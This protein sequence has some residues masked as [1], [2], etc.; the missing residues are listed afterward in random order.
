MFPLTRCDEGSDVALQFAVLP[1]PDA[2]SV[3]FNVPRRR[4][5]W[6]WSPAWHAISCPAY[7][8]SKFSFISC[9]VLD[10][11]GSHDAVCPV[12]SLQPLSCIRLLLLIPFLTPS[13]NLAAS[14]SSSIFKLDLRFKASMIPP[15]F[16]ASQTGNNGVHHD[17]AI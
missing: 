5:D 13:L 1:Q 12:K 7:H 15:Q 2:S 3:Q 11:S 8:C 10:R 9:V 14:P 17:A 4:S 6:F 16:D